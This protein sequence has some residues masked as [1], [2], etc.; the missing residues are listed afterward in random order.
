MGRMNEWQDGHGAVKL[1]KGHS[2][3][4]DFRLSVDKFSALIK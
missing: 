1:E 3:P 2:N 4:Q